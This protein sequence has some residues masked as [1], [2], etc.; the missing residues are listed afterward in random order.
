MARKLY[1]FARWADPRPV[2]VEREQ[3]A[4]GSKNPLRPSDVIVECCKGRVFYNVKV[5]NPFLAARQSFSRI[6]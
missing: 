3:R 5:V 1:E 6:A 4:A 2:T